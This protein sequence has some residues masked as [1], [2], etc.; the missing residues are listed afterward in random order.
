VR[1]EP[2]KPFSLTFDIP[3]KS[4]S[5]LLVEGT[6]FHY[7]SFAGAVGMIDS[8]EIWATN[9]QFL[10][11]SSEFQHGMDL[12]LE[13]WFTIRS[14]L[15]PAAAARI[16]RLLD[17]IV[18]LHSLDDAFVIS[19][20]SEPEDVGQFDRYGKYSLELDVE[21]FIYPAGNEP[22][23]P[24]TLKFAS[25][26]PAWR[27]VA[28][29]SGEKRARIEE[30]FQDIA[31]LLD[32]KADWVPARNEIITQWCAWW[33]INLVAGLKDRHFQSEAEIRYAVFAESGFKDIYSRPSP[34]GDATYVRTSS[35]FKD[36]AKAPLPLH[37]ITVSPRDVNLDEIAEI[38]AAL[39]RASLEVPVELSSVPFR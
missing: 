7:T 23:F 1:I 30:F 34:Y 36:G 4:D 10:N 5:S 33:Y 16:D 14:G 12:V 25:L 31:V 11:D 15:A 29:G 13:E 26:R 32:S 8:N 3:N 17:S 9:V 20:S 2:G 21:R 6:V 37:R 19:A 22:Q 39:S 24:N 35:N 28:Y 38:K 18:A 27:T